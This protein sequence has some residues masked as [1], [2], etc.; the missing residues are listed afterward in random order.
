MKKEAQSLIELMIS[1]SIFVLIV[2]AIGFLILDSLAATRTGQETT[3]AVFLAEEGL[4]ATQ[5][6]NEVT[7]EGLSVGAHGLAVNDNHWVFSG[8]QEDMSEQLKQGVRTVVISEIEEGVKR[9]TST[10]SW[11]LTPLRSSEVSLTTYFADWRAEG[12]IPE[13][14]SCDEY[15]QW[16]DIYE[17][18]SCRQ[19]ENFCRHAGGVYEKGGDDFCHPPNNLCCC[20]E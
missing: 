11:Q 3:L 19:N 2:S 5:S 14:E 4:E 16:L 8:T 1:L 7:W 6:I 9:A 12:R 17:S 13:F 15:C 18:G 10:V 20:F